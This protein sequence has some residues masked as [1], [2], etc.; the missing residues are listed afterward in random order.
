MLQIISSFFCLVT[1]WILVIFYEMERRL[2]KSR[3]R[4]LFH[5]DTL[6]LNCLLYIGL[7]RE[8]VNRTLIW[9][10]EPEPQKRSLDMGIMLMSIWE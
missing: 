9:S 2:S 6:I 8:M 7:G 1:L 5:F 10:S 4:P 3:Q